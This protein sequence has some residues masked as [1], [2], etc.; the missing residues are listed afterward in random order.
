MDRLT[1]MQRIKLLKPAAKMMRLPQPRIYNF[2]TTPAIGKIVKK[3]E[4][5]GVVTSI[6]RLV[7]YHFARFAEKNRFCK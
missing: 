1:I 7:H 4:D 5:S 6:E 2:P 3:Y